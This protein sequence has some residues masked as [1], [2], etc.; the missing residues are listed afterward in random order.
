[1]K[2]GSRVTNTSLDETTIIDRYH[3]LWRIEKSFRI[4]KSD[5][6]ARPIF[7]KL[8]NTITCHLIIRLVRK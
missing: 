8:D 5:L 4:T 7:L 1:M 6:E 3:D 2:I